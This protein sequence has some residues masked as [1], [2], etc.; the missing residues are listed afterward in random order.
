MSNA[1][2]RVKGAPDNTQS[3]LI[4]GQDPSNTGTPGVAA[5]TQVSVDAI[6]EVTIQTSNYAAEYG[7]VGGGFFNYTMKSG[8]NQFHGTGYDYFANEA[9]NAGTPFTN[10]G[11]GSLLR[12]AARRNDY[13]ATLGGPVWIPHIYNGRDKTFFF[14]NFEQFREFETINNQS[15][16][17]PIPA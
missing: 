16:T 8:T 13:G 11:N 5:Q 15:I 17:V 1:E 14:F 9:L 7:Q 3:F 2:V 10:N 12:P 6:Q 4:E